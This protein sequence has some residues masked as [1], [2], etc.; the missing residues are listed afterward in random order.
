M[1]TCRLSLCAAV[2]VLFALTTPVSVAQAPTPEVALQYRPAQ[3]DVEY[4]SPA[5]ADIKKCVV[6]LERGEGKSGF[7]VFDP[8][9]QII[10]R[11][12]DTNSDRYID[13]WRYF[14]LGIEVYRDVD[15]NFDKKIDQSRWLNTGGS[16][17][18]I[19]SNQDGKIDSWR[20][21]SAEEASRV[22][23]NAM[24]AGDAGL[25]STVLVSEG[26]IRKLGITKEFST[27]LLKQVASPATALRAAMNTKSLTGDSKWTRFDAAMP[28]LIPADDQKAA[29]DLMVY[30]GAM[31]IVETRG[32]HGFIQIGEMVR[33]GNV[34]KLTQIPK[35]MTGNTIQV[36][37]GGLLMRP[38]IGVPSS[39]DVGTELTPQMA[40][41]IQELQK[42]DSNPPRQDASPAQVLSYLGKRRGIIVQL[43]NQ[44]RTA[45]E[46]ETWQRQLINLLTSIAQT[47]D[48]GG[49]TELVSIENDLRKRTPGSG[50][51]PYL[52][53][54][55]LLGQYSLDLRGTTDQKKQQQLQETWLKSLEQFV[56]QFPKAEDAP[57]ALLQL[58]VNRELSGSTDGA[59]QDYLQLSSGYA[60]TPQGKRASGALR[61]LEL[62]GREM[63]LFGP[64][65]SGRKIDVAAYR[66]K[67]LLVV[68]WASW[69][70][71]FVDDIPVLIGLHNQYKSKGF[72]IVGVSLD[73]QAAG[74]LPFIKQNKMTWANIFQ[75]GV[76]DS[77]LAQ[78]YGILT[79]PTMFLIGPDG[80][81]LS[82]GI[83]LSELKDTLRKRLD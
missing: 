35:P 80:K 14:R 76:F 7:T 13:Q 19:D 27:E 12:V 67:L 49:I 82:S 15:S 40:A 65:P 9:G 38:A 34:W 37:M 31:A 2:A 73:T 30:E 81:V 54:R 25:L 1:L 53:Y 17:W 16:R 55:R 74:V 3:N 43:V 70:G 24:I 44:S 47:G 48:K 23:V 32:Q 42:L 60:D 64:D 56:K 69:S 21:L 66:G 26:D 10:R 41:R 5:A 50:L 29:E 36:A 11:Y 79:A 6:K 39:T 4:D 20:S 57:D 58:A 28:G 61:R 33:V 72:E 59:R 52:A 22:A 51:V 71:E 68:F 75:P 45:Q 77:P 46:R 63:P 8:S 83:S 62:V 78:Q 18:S